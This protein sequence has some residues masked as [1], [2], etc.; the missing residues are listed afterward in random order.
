MKARSFDPLTLLRWCLVGLAML[1]YAQVSQAGTDASTA[2]RN[3]D[4]VTRA[5]AAW[6]AGGQS[7]FDDILAPDV[8]WTVK[9]SGPSAGVYRGRQDL[10]ERAVKPLSAKLAKP[11][12]PTVRH[13]L[14]EGDAVVIHWD[15]EAETRDGKPYRNSY[16]W[17]FRMQGGRATEVAAFLDLAAY[18]A[19]VHGSAE[20]A[21]QP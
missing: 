21:K 19:V 15:G 16:V 7:F 8:V 5:F 1:A 9:G 14:A 18:D 6:T 17:I 20:V 12:R 11:I 13:L 3:R 4:T 10:V 2:Q